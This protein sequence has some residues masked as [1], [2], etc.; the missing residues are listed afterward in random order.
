MYLFKFIKNIY[1]KVT[2]K[3]LKII[4]LLFSF[5]IFLEFISYYTSEKSNYEVFKSSNLI[6][7]IPKPLIIEDVITVKVLNTYQYIISYFLLNLKYI[8]MLLVCFIL[9]ILYYL[10]NKALLYILKRIYFNILYVYSN[11]NLI[12]DY[13]VLNHIDTLD[14]IPE[15]NSP[16]IYIFIYKNIIIFSVFIVITYILFYYFK[17]LFTRQIIY[18]FIPII[19]F[20]NLFYDDLEICKDFKTLDLSFFKSY[21]YNISDSFEQ[22]NLLKN[23]D[24]SNR[25]NESLYKLYTIILSQDFNS[26]SLIFEK[27]KLYYN[28]ME[29]MLFEQY[30]SSS[31]IVTNSNG[32]IL[33]SQ[34]LIH[35]NSYNFKSD[36]NIKKDRELKSES[37]QKEGIPYISDAIYNSYIISIDRTN[38]EQISNL[39]TTDT[40]FLSALESPSQNPVHNFNT[41][42]IIQNPDII[43]EEEL[44]QGYI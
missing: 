18:Y 42:P 36:A 2:F 16:F 3:T 30:E 9:F 6:E 28:S 44:K 21:T 5:V 40:L 25:Y 23:I 4:L 14:N 26:I 27:M 41:Q 33:D 22:N 19:S 37:D 17:D 38:P 31:N 11:I 35:I 34:T 29:D 10:N 43:I 1:K 15:V 7:I 32:N 8:L 20:S 13:E 24:M 12:L 39:D